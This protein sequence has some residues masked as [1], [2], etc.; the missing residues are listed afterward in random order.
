MSYRIFRGA[1]S[2]RY[3]NLANEL[4]AKLFMQK[5]D[6]GLRRV[7]GR[8]AA[9]GNN[10]IRAGLLECIYAGANSGNGGALSNIVEGG[11]I[12]ILFT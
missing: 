4:A 11:R 1:E 8:P 7:D 5:E 10:D 6:D 2:R 12:S 3:G 9:D